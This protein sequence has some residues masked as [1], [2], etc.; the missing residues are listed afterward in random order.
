MCICIFMGN[1]LL[2]NT[3][4]INNPWRIIGRNENF[5]FK[6][7]ARMRLSH[8]T[9][10]RDLFILT[11]NG[12]WNLWSGGPNSISRRLRLPHTWPPMN[13]FIWPFDMEVDAIQ[14]VRLVWVFREIQCVLLY[15]L[16]V[17]LIGP[18]HFIEV[19]LFGV[20]LDLS[21]FPSCTNGF[22]LCH[23]RRLF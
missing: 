8:S 10:D 20:Q 23:H 13:C 9:N 5:V 3:N 7:L 16:R 14:C 6:N 15:Q 12:K 19:D 17:I 4:R 21:Q 11:L 1:C 2:N 18:R 22:A